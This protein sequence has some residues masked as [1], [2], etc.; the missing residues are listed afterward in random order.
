M[1]PT[2]S[3]LVALL[4]ALSPVTIASAESSEIVVVVNKANSVTSLNKAQLSAIYKGKTT[5]FPNGNSAS[6]VNLP[7]E[8][9]TRQE[10]DKAVLNMSSDDC[11][12]YWIDMKIRSGAGAPPKLASVSAVARHVAKT[13]NAI[14]YVLLSDAT[15]L[16]VVARI[17]AGALV[18]P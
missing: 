8:N 17:R 1:Q 14:G 5:E 15:G 2:K 6:A 4:I 7:A 9:P 18:G 10:F 12:R 11:K 3:L 16:K 13:P